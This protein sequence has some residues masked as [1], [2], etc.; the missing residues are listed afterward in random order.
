MVP[1]QRQ[2]ADWVMDVQGARRVWRTEEGWLGWQRGSHD[3]GCTEN[4][5]T[6]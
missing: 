6:I 2:G 3:I 4:K 1:K 5:R